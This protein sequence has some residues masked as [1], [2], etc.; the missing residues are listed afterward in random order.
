MSQGV[1]VGTPPNAQSRALKGHVFR[2]DSGKS[3]RSLITDT[4]VDPQRR[5]VKE[6]V[7][8]RATEGPLRLLPGFL[9]GGD[10]LTP[11]QNLHNWCVRPLLFFNNPP[12]PRP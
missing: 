10:P 5:S 8:S 9:H 2:L 6:V 12:P 11:D 7:Q 3:K 4:S 1:G